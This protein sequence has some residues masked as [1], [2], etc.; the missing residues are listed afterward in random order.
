MPNGGESTVPEGRFDLG[1]WQDVLVALWNA[2]EGIHEILIKEIEAYIER[3]AGTSEK[4]ELANADLQ[5]WLQKQ[6]GLLCVLV[7]INKTIRD[8]VM[9]F[10]RSIGA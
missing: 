2:Q 5:A 3:M 10:L 4:S 6:Q 1:T 8:L 7:M 9:A